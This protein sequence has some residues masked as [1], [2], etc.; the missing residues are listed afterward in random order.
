MSWVPNLSTE[1][2]IVTGG[3]RNIGLSIARALSWA[4]ASVCVVGRNDTVSRDDA[5]AKL[6]GEGK[7]VM[8]QLT[9][10]SDETSVSKLF[11]T[12]EK[13]LGPVT[14]LVNGAAYR[15]HVPFTD[16]SL[17]E[18]NNVQGT[19]LTGAFLMA[20]EF[21]RRL[22]NQKQGAIINLGGL[23]AHR[24][25]HNRAHVIAAKAGL[26]GLTRALASEY[27]G[28]IRV[29]CLVP[30]AIDTER[31]PGQSVPHAKEGGAIPLGKSEDVARVAL[32]FADPHHTYATGQTIHI[33]GGRFMS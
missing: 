29:N 4:G 2:A 26:I 11:N 12:V 21:L 17:T 32:L 19:I 18:W 6:G 31:R 22:P 20:R 24:G 1:T 10:V 27:A 7:R 23:S 33:N 3:T 14:I 9:D 28:R 8:T 15:P 30:G 13:K 25:G 5:L 16:M